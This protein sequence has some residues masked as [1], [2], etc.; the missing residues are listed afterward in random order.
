MSVDNQM[1]GLFFFIL[2]SLLPGLSHAQPPTTSSATQQVSTQITRGYRLLYQS[3]KPQEAQHVFENAQLLAKHKQSPQRARW[4][5]LSA[6]ISFLLGQSYEKQ[7]FWAQAVFAYRRCLR[8][9]PAQRIQ[10]VTKQALEQLLKRHSAQLTISSVPVGA[11]V[12]VRYAQGWLREGTTPHTF[13]VLQGNVVLRLSQ[14]GYHTLDKTL[15]GILA[16][17]SYKRHFPMRLV[18]KP[19]AAWG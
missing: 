19:G 13:A 16:G 1:W 8:G 10:K 9:T 17:R 7:Q 15:P 5:R 3:S 4:L 2:G 12:E 14:K 18:K 11:T 6:N